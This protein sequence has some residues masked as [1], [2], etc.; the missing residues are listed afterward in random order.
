LSG[1]VAVLLACLKSK[2]DFKINKNKKSSK[3]CFFQAASDF[4]NGKGQWLP[5]WNLEENNGEQVFTFTLLDFTVV[6]LNRNQFQLL[7]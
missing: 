2:R 4:W 1:P 3:Y 7:S 5:T 6:I